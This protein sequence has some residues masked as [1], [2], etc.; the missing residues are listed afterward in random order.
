[1]HAIYKNDEYAHTLDRAIKLLFN[2]TCR[3]QWTLVKFI[4]DEAQSKQVPDILRGLE[5]FFDYSYY[6]V[7]LE[8]YF[9]KRNISEFPVAKFEELVHLIDEEIVKNFN[10]KQMADLTLPIFKLFNIDFDEQNALVPI[11]ALSVFFDDK[12][13]SAIVERLNDERQE[14]GN[15]SV[16]MLE[17]QQ[18]IAG[19]DFAVGVE[20]SALVNLH[21]SGASPSKED[22]TAS[23]Y[24]KQ[25]IDEE[26]PEQYL[27]EQ[28]E[29]VLMPEESELAEEVK[30]DTVFS[31]PEFSELEF[32]QSELHE[33]TENEMTSSM[34]VDEKKDA[35][36]PVKAKMPEPDKVA[37]EF[38]PFKM[39]DSLPDLSVEFEKAFEDED[40]DTMGMG[41][42]DAEFAK[43]EKK[44]EDKLQEFSFDNMR[45]GKSEPEPPD[46]IEQPRTE[47][48][49]PVSQKFTTDTDSIAKYGDLR[50][51]I[52]SGDKKKYIKKIFGRNDEKYATAIDVLNKKVTWKEASEYI[53]EIFLNN[54]VDMYSRIAV[55][56]TDE[57]YKRYLPKK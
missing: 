43:D 17:L 13:N 11:E 3:P 36:Q 33:K 51:L 49:I 15:I 27:P 32:G 39:D 54:D 19:V 2:Y 41:N 16:T 53:D 35:G 48:E 45:S 57:I 34:P 55:H 44:K 18:L 31:V 5:F 56:F 24:D 42:L 4:F 9:S 23:E 37:E 22:F 38:A 30:G 40:S 8:K 6:K 47:K 21:L 50:T 52:S 20:I 26:L 12:G 28:V 7:V 25:F 29:S 14:K 46:D 1:M 10:S